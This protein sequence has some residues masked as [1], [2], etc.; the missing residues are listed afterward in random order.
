MLPEL[1]ETSLEI[2]PQIW[3]SIKLE[4]P[5]LGYQLGSR[6][7]ASMRIVVNLFT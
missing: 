5:V 2:D 7:A 4:V 3:S 1:V 6:D